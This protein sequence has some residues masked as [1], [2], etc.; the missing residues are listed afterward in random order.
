[1]KKICIYLVTTLLLTGLNAC[2]DNDFLD[3]YPIDKETE[4]TVFTSYENFK[5]YAWGFYNKI[6]PGY[7]TDPTLTG[8]V[9]DLFIDTSTSVGISWANDRISPSLISASAWKDPYENIR[10]INVMLDNLDA[11][12]SQLTEDEQAHWRGVGYFF[13]AY[14]YFGLLRVF[15]DLQW[16]EHVVSTT[17]RDLLYGKR[18]SREVVADNVLNNL[19]Y[20]E[21]NI[22]PEGDGVNTI[23]PNVVRALI[24][25]FGLFEGT[26]R[27]YHGSVDGVDGT[28]YLEASVAAS[29]K[30]IDQ[31]LGL[32]P[33][34]DDVFNSLSLS[35]QSSILLYREYEYE[36]GKGHDL[37][38][39]STW[40]D[41]EATKKLLE[42]YLCKDGKPVST[43]SFY[44]GDA[45]MYDEF[46]NRDHRLYYTICP[47]YRVET[48]GDYSEW[49]YTS[50]PAEREYIDLM[51]EL[52]G[53]DSKRKML[54]LYTGTYGVEVPNFTEVAQNGF[55]TNCGYHMYKYYNS[56]DGSLNLSDRGATDCPTFRMGEVLVNHA[57]AMWELGRFNQA[58]ADVTIN[59]LRVRAN[60]DAM[61]VSQI[62]ADFDLY[63]DSDVDPVLWEIRRERTVELMGS[64][65][66]FSDIKRWKKGD[67][68]TQQPV[69]A[70]V[71]NIDDY[72]ND[73][74]K[75]RLYNG[76]QK[77]RWKNCLSYI[78]KPNPGWLEKC[79]LY[80][81]PLTQTILNPNLGQNPGWSNE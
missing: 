43:S 49:R 51:N 47:P 57:E 55:S 63:R 61:V 22:K 79:Y 81:I 8:D 18:D 44:D 39:R 12:Q 31:N 24:S 46:R 7:S 19:L 37:S 32:I 1:M 21:Q 77:S 13:R 20:A 70:K 53:G 52:T 54:P 62:G 73:S 2:L 50:N 66:R 56:Y 29:Q 69:G 75:G 3:R 36:S 45:T 14:V 80:P 15:G 72:N 40:T 67:Y 59:P 26:W 28:K 78:V 9:S 10:R 34:Y 16:V 71:T 17:D 38:N 30:L 5:M 58:V 11:S 27:K 68:L 35:G 25:R 4:V 76:E 6:L 74:L 64:G 41:Y 33:D 23:N 48:N 42:M 60:V 65:F